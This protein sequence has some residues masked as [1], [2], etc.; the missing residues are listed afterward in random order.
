MK[1]DQEKL[2]IIYEALKEKLRQY[3]I[4]RRAEKI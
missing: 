2:P 1:I 4:L 3:C